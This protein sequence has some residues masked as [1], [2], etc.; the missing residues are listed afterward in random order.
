MNAEL[1]Y[2]VMQNHAAELRRVAAEERRAR[3]ARQGQRSG[4]RSVFSRLLAS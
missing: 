1:E 4:R 3:E 2:V